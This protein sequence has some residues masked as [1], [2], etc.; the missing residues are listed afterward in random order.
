MEILKPHS[1]ECSDDLPNLSDL[2]GKYTFM[3]IYIKVLNRRH[4][5]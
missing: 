3:N 1:D 2:L 4:Y 5:E